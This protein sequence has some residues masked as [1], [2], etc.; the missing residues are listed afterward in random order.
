[1]KR[2]VFEGGVKNMSK[3]NPGYKRKGEDS[4]KK[5]ITKGGKN[6]TKN[7]AKNRP[8]MGFVEIRNI[9]EE[10]ENNRRISRP[11]PK[12]NRSSPA[13]RFLLVRKKSKRR[14]SQT[15][16]EVPKKKQSAY[17]LIS[18]NERSA[19]SLSPSVETERK[20]KTAGGG[21]PSNSANDGP[22]LD[23]E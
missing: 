11:P 15:S 10:N 14:G 9:H 6:T 5:I 20:A 3:E 12:K 16:E 4:K 1:M 18:L 22:P 23:Q 8:A 7:I 19:S 2:I 13:G 21:Q 17:D